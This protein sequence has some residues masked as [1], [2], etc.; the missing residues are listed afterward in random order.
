M[1]VQQVTTTQHQWRYV[2]FVSM[3]LMGS[4]LFMLLHGAS[5]Q[6]VRPFNNSNA[7]EGVT[8][9][10]APHS[11][12]STPGGEDLDP[13]DQGGRVAKAPIAASS[14]RLDD[15]DLFDRVLATDVNSP[16]LLLSDVLWLRGPPPF[17]DDER[18]SHRLGTGPVD[19]SFDALDDDDDG[20]DDG[21]T[22][23]GDGLATQVTASA[24]V[25]CA[26]YTS[27]LLSRLEVHHPDSHSSDA[28]SLRAPPQ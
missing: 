7:C 13:P 16:S 12:T 28:Q 22:D 10:R 1:A 21:D 24:G 14:Q 19:A 4:G 25:S 18:Q 15:T 23:D 6:S 20:D 11:M 27:S 9:P 26:L 5:P 17:D 3:L 8:A 2:P